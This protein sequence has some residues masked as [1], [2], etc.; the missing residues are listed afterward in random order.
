MVSIS[1]VWGLAIIG[2]SM[3]PLIGLAGQLSLSQLT[4]AAFGAIAYAHL[5]WGNPLGLVWAAVAA[6]GIGVLVALPAIRLQGIYIA[7]ATAAFTV[8]CDRWL[9]PLPEFHIGSHSFSVFQNGSL[10]VVRPNF[11]GLDLTS[12][13]SYFVYS[14]AV[15][16]LLMLAVVALRRSFVGERLI[17]VKEGPAALASCGIN[18]TAMKLAV[19]AL[20]AAIAGVGGAVLTAAEPTNHSAFNLVAGLPVLL[21]MVI[22]G[23]SSVGSPIFVGVFLGSPLPSKVFSSFGRW[24]NILI[25]FAGVALG[26][27]PNGFSAD[28]RPASARV[29]RDTPVLV[30]LV[31]ALLALWGLRIADAYSNGPYLALS[32]GALVAAPVV[33]A[34]RRTA[35]HAGEDEEVL[36]SGTAHALLGASHG[37]GL[38]APP[39]LLGLSEPF[40]EDDVIALD[41]AVDLARARAQLMAGTDARR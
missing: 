37:H 30:G 18:V 35:I 28:I 31:T 24:Q 6:A 15:F 32:L 16:V 34:R 23:I 27:N 21:T 9:F 20:S 8:L 17:A 13:T 12:P 14:S 33:A 41:E 19:F 1:K 25:G 3:V 5:G 10:P 26:N 29:K 38:H 22:A 7:L 39:E 11:L 36:D 40:T 4:F 2:L